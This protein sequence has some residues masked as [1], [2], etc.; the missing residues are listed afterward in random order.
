MGGTGFVLRSWVG[1]TKRECHRI[2]VLIV[3]LGESP[4]E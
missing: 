2:K 4:E 1:K 3:L